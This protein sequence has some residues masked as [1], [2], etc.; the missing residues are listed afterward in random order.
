MNKCARGTAFSS[1]QAAEGD[2]ERC[3]DEEII[4][5]EGWTESVL[6]SCAGPQTRETRI[7]VMCG[8]FVIDV[9]VVEFQAKQ[10]ECQAG[11]L[12]E[13]LRISS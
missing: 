13:A 5:D 6:R 10:D 3:W 2:L 7:M 12:L 1:Q 9:L 4:D 8:R 11:F